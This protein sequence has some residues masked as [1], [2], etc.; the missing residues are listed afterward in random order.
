M[1]AGPMRGVALTSA[2]TAD[3]REA[4]EGQGFSRRQ[5]LERSGAV[6]VAFGAG[7]A[8]AG[9]AG[10]RPAAAQGF[11]GAGSERLDSWLAI[12]ADGLLYGFADNRA[13]VFDTATGAPTQVATFPVGLSIGG[14]TQ[15][16]PGIEGWFVGSSQADI[17]TGTSSDE[18]FAPHA[19]NDVVN[20]QGGTDGVRMDGNRTQFSVE[21]DG[22][23][24]FVTA[25][26]GNGGRDRL[27]SIERLLF[28][29]QQISLQNL[30]D[31]TPP[32]YNG[33]PGFLFDEVFYLLDNPELVPTLAA[34]DARSPAEKHEVIVLGILYSGI[35]LILYPLALRL[36]ARVTAA[37]RDRLVAAH[38]FT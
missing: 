34:A 8:G 32:T 37:H 12:G 31:T 10:G 13:Y 17:L 4:L 14:A 24:W 18:L 15:T 9:V 22:L 35:N 21:R 23:E 16:A 30:P 6:I 3:A 36:V 38:I 2:L 7:M 5:F 29:D 33:S 28:N 11:N 20:G 26:S 27:I 25:L 1:S 19:G